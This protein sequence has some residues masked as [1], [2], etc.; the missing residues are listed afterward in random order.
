MTYALLALVVI[1]TLFTVSMTVLLIEVLH[2]LNWLR[3]VLI[4]WIT[5]INKKL[6]LP[7]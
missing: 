2:K 5:A 7:K 6:G 3:N 1:L 4:P